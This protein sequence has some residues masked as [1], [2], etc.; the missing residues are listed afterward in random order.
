MFRRSGYVPYVNRYHVL[1][2]ENFPLL[3]FYS[4]VLC[5]ANTELMSLQTCVIYSTHI[6]LPVWALKH[7]SSYK[8]R[9]HFT[10]HMVL[11]VKQ[12]GERKQ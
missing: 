8:Q 2:F 5:S 11:C 10:F 1:L 12:Q 6:C 9:V 7:H 4:V 3:L